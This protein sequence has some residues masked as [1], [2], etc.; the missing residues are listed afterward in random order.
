MMTIARHVWRDPPQWGRGAF[1]PTSR[2]Y[3]RARE[4]LDELLAASEE[5]V[6]TLMTLQ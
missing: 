1:G 5:L 4:R 2:P 3:D 6:D